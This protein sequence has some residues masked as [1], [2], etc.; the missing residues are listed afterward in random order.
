MAKQLI[1]LL[2]EEALNESLETIYRLSGMQ[3]HNFLKRIRLS[4][5]NYGRESK[6]P[7]EHLSQSSINAFNYLDTID[8]IDPKSITNL[9]IASLKETRELREERN[10]LQAKFGKIDQELKEIKNELKVVIASNYAIE[11]ALQTHK[12]NIHEF[13]E[14]ASKI[15]ERRIGP[16]LEERLEEV[17]MHEFLKM[18]LE[19]LRQHLGHSI[20]EFTTFIGR[21]KSYYHKRKH[22]PID[23]LTSEEIIFFEDM[24]LHKRFFITKEDEYNLRALPLTK[25]NYKKG[26]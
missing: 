19:E 20:S 2:K 4:T 24:K 16:R 13:A 10:Q 17:D 15:V 14:D 6:L 25:L 26:Y 3:F 9:L 5:K 23:S 18:T 22:R 12:R 21:S 8:E 7:F 1:P 11:D